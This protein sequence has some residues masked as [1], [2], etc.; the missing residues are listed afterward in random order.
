M[1]KKQREYPLE[2]P[3]RITGGTSANGRQALVLAGK[4][5]VLQPVLHTK[6]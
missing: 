3:C 1:V 5:A 2:G 6:V 4:L